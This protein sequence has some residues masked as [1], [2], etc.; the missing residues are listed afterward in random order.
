MRNGKRILSLVLLALLVVLLAPGAAHADPPKGDTHLHSWSVISEKA[1]T[2]TEPGSKTWRC[3]AC[4]DTYT[5]QTSP[6]LGHAFDNGRVTKEATC[7][8][9]GVKR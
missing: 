2:C 4:G 8:Q 1:A 5:E 7:T 6:A 9:E 3:S